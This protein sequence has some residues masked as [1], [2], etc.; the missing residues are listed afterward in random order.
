MLNHGDYLDFKIG[1]T[2]QAAAGSH[3]L[4]ITNTSSTD[5]GLFKTSA[6]ATGAFPVG[7]A[8]RL[9][10]R[11][12][13]DYDHSLR[14]GRETG[15][16]FQSCPPDKSIQ[17]ENPYVFVAVDGGTIDNEPLELARR[18]LAS[19]TGKSHN[20]RA[21]DEADRAVV[22]IAPFPNFQKTPHEDKK[23]RIID[24]IPRLFFSALIQQARFKP[25]ELALAENDDVF[26]RYI[27]SPT[28]DYGGQHLLASKYPIACGV[29]GAFGGFLHKSFRQHDYLLGRRNAQAFLRWHFGLPENNKLFDG[30]DS[31]REKWRVRRPGDGQLKP[32][33]TKEGDKHG[34]PIIPLTPD[35]I[36]EIV[37]DKK[38]F[39]DP[40]FLTRG[41]ARE[42]LVTRIEARADKVIRTLI[43]LDFEQWTGGWTKLPARIGAIRILTG[44]A[45]SKAKEEIQK[46]IQDVR[47]AFF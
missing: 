16:G 46:A 18:Y 4:D 43:D 12:V 47:D 25:D 38:Y 41:N 8:P 30:Y 23:D 28:R 11:P 44:I 37:I 21:G 40:D 15:A 7:L 2:P 1:V 32:Y 33:K 13:L 3:A 10:S 34:L 22:M 36:R 27:I 14:V 9:I 5:W 39:P 17:T 26:S 35:M 24:V 19:G 6:K 42:K 29:L 20:N 31:G 45:A